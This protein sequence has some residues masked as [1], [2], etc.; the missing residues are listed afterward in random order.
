MNYLIK[1]LNLDEK[2]RE[3][4]VKN[5]VYYLSDVELLAVILRSGGKGESAIEL[6]RTILEKYENLFGLIGV[7][8]K[9]LS[10]VKN[11]DIAKASSVIAAIEMGL[12]L[13]KN[14]NT[15]AQIE[16]KKPQDVADLLKK[17]ILGKTKEHLFLISLN[18]RNRLISTDLISIGTIAETLMSP[19]E[20]FRQAVLRN[21]TAIVLAHN[22]PSNDP[23][24]SSEDISS[25]NRVAAAA[26]EFGLKFLDHIILTNNGYS[27]LKH[28]GFLD[29]KEVRS[30]V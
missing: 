28:L 13:G 24:P 14:Q 1:D 22:H 5:G 26:Q 6:A 29:R 9:Q 20:I 23:N 17:D 25:T 27:S 7:D 8:V 3:K 4:I 12:R 21:A 30:D 15:K 19:R 10:Q 11:I 16:V 2:P 18:A